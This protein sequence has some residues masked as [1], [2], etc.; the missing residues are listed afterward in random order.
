MLVDWIINC[1]NLGFPV[2]KGDLC[3][4]VQKLVK[5]SGLECPLFIDGLPGKKWYYAF[6]KRHSVIS[7]KHAEYVNRARG[8]VT[9]ERVKKWFEEVRVSLKDHIDVLNDHTRVFNMDETC[10]CLAP[11]GDLI[12]G[13]KGRQVYDESSNSDKENADGL[14][15]PPLT[16]FKYERIPANVSKAA[17][18]NWGIRKTENGWMTGESFYEYIANV[19]LPFL[20]QSKIQL[21][22]IVFLDGH[23]SHLT[24]HLSQFCRE[25]KI[26][27]GGLVAL[28]PNSTHFL[29]PLD[30]AV[31]DPLKKKWK[32][33]VRK[34][35]MDNHG[36]EISKADVPSALSQI[37]SIPDMKKKHSI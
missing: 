30:V 22:V 12:L 2:N 11:K 18:P 13:P 23:K 29:Q 8:A 20:V 37:I 36:K 3:L 17:P 21:P 14:F 25:N 1:A 10:F 26:V 24:L 34:W 33:I 27:L 7:Q 31:F 28:Y 15:A 9:E 32:S 35:R 6:L 5:T 4:S 16:I 19:F